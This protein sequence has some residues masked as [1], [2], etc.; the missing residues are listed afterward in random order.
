M[1]LRSELFHPKKAAKKMVKHFD[2]KKKLFGC[3]DQT[4]NVTATNINNNNIDG[5]NNGRKEAV[6]VLAR[7]ILMSD[8]NDDDMKVLESGFMQIL[9]KPD[10][11]GRGV[12]VFSPHPLNLKEY[13]NPMVRVVRY[14]LHFPSLLFVL[15]R[16]FILQILSIAKAVQESINR[17]FFLLWFSI[18][19]SS[20]IFVLS[21]YPFLPFYFQIT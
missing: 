20:I 19:S 10:A 3:P 11:A 9:P 7:S 8:L 6:H 16:F 5:K 18:S 1:F 13:F 2:L 21:L 15:V 4:S 12:I 14:Y 17:F